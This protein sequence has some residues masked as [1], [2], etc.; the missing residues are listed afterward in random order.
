MNLHVCINIPQ[1]S[2]TVVPYSGFDARADSDA[3]R[4]AMKGFGTDEKTIINILAN[5]TNS[6]RQEIALMFK[7]SYGKVRKR[8][9]KAKNWKL[10]IRVVLIFQDLIKDLK[11]E[12]TGNF[13]TLVIA[14]VTPLPQFYA[15]E[16]HNAMSGMGTDE[17]VL[18]E[19]LCTLSNNEIRTIRQAFQSSG[20]NSR[21]KFELLR[22]SN[23]IVIIVFLKCTE[24]LSRTRWGR[25]PQDISNVLWFR[26]A[27]LIGTN[28]IPSIQTWSVPT[29]RLSTTL[30]CLD[31]PPMLDSIEFVLILN[32]FSSQEKESGVP[33]SRFSIK[34]W[35]NEA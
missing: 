15:K 35:Y 2:P 11:S 1:L 20:F 28:R 23:L 12:L 16:L 3:L 22:D 5:R 8:V 4:K 25:T 18:I 32:F 34:F 33:T 21:N 30:V 24:D 14:M 31:G 29:P 19:V 27:L 9:E 10:T 6:Q 13:E 26:C 7:T 17:C